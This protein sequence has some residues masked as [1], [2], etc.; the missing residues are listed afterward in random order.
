MAVPDRKS[1][2]TVAP[3]GSPCATIVT[4]IVVLATWL[5]V[6]VKNVNAETEMVLPD[7]RSCAVPVVMV[8]MFPASR[9]KD[10]V[11]LVVNVVATVVGT[12]V[13]IGN[14]RS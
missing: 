4:V 8:T 7:F 12:V 9:K 10:A 1:S 6:P 11:V 13:G 14:P 3:L 2:D 5:Y